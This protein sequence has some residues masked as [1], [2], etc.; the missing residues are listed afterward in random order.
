MLTLQ[1]LIFIAGIFH[2]ALVIGS[3][4]IP[5]LLNWNQELEKVSVLI[6]QIFWTYAGYILGTNLCFGLLSVFHTEVLTNGS[7]LAGYVCL[8]IA[9]YWMVRIA[10]QFFYFDRPSAPKG[11]IYDL[12]EISLVA[13]FIF[14]TLVYGYAVYFNFFLADAYFAS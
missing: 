2:I 9:L 14:F 11:F 1:I 13:L 3:T 5:V 7:P 8:F 10:V 12:G 4:F 6:K